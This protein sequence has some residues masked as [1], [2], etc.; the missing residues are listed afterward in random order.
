VGDREDEGWRRQGDGCLGR[1]P[2]S[3]ERQF[4]P[5]H[6]TKSV[7][8]ATPSLPDPS[9]TTVKPAEGKPQGDEAPKQPG[10]GLVV[11]SFLVMGGVTVWLIIGRPFEPTSEFSVTNSTRTY[12][13]RW[14]YPIFLTVATLCA[15]FSTIVN[16]RGI[17]QVMRLKSNIGRAIVLF[18]VALTTFGLITFCGIKSYYALEQIHIDGVYYVNRMNAYHF[19]HMLRNELDRRAVLPTSLDDIADLMAMPSSHYV[20]PLT[21]QKAVWNVRVVNNSFL[22]YSDP[23]GNLGHMVMADQGDFEYHVTSQ[24]LSEHFLW[25]RTT[26]LK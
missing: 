15:L 19:K 21:K 24:K 26:L 5:Q 7:M 13:T 17:W 12:V 1:N 9:A 10:L 8:N 6:I 16:L 25:E 23:I 4:L 14:N 22:I 11:L 20:N 2:D 3:S 18:T